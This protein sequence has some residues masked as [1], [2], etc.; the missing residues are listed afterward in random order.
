[1]ARENNAKVRLIQAYLAAGRGVDRALRYHL[2]MLDFLKELSRT[3]IQIFQSTQTRG[4][5]L[6]LDLVYERK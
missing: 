1:M 5:G 6:Q 2:R 4:F 3:N